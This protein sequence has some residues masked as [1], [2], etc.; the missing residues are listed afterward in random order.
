MASS[1]CSSAATECKARS[2][3]GF[4]TDCTSGAAP[5]CVASG[6]GDAAGAAWSTGASVGDSGSISV[7][8]AGAATRGTTGGGAEACAGAAGDDSGTGGGAACG[9]EGGGGACF[10]SSCC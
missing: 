9:A 5:V 2:C 8:A 10:S 1:H 3:V 4:S 7:V 6:S